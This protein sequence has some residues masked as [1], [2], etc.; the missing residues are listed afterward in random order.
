MTSYGSRFSA[1]AVNPRM[2]ANK[3]ARDFSS[4]TAL[5]PGL[6][7][8]SSTSAS[9]TCTS[10]CKCAA[11]A[12]SAPVR[13]AQFST[14]SRTITRHV[15]QRAFPPQACVCGIPARM[16]ALSNVSSARASTSSSS[17]R[18]RTRAMA[19]RSENNRIS[20]S[21]YEHFIFDAMCARTGEQALGRL[22][23]R[24]EAETESSVMHRHQSFRAKF[25]ECFHCLFRIHVHLA[26]SRC[27]IGADRQQRDVDLVM[28][29]D[30]PEAGKIRAVTAMENGTAPSLDHESAEAA[31]QIS[32][33]PRAPV[34]TRRQGNLERSEFHRLPVIQF[35]HNLK[36]EIVHKIANADRHNDRLIRCHSPQR[37]PVEMVEMRMRHQ[38]EIDF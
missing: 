3:I 11:I 20:F 1:K 12:C 35:V 22:V 27:V 2:Y 16:L 21:H 24:L 9:R 34:I 10:N 18:N 28:L 23:Q 4:P 33:E 5:I 38:H 17:G 13:G 15:E 31:M 29:P 25:R 26:T 19:R 7:I 30:F 32:Q 14:P 6:R 37:S 36:P 8:S